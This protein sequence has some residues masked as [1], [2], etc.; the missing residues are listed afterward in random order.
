M[1]KL[2]EIN[3]QLIAIN[4]NLQKIANNL[5]PNQKPKITITKEELELHS[6]K[7]AEKIKSDERRLE[8]R[9]LWQKFTGYIPDDIEGY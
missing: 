7:Y 2:S 3:K 1:C 5:Q 6:K 9:T 4:K 8:E